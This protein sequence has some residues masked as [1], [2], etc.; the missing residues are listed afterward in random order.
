MYTLLRLLL[1][2]K[3]SAK[4]LQIFGMYKTLYKNNSLCLHNRLF[5]CKGLS[6][7]LQCERTFEVGRCSRAGVLE[8]TTKI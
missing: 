1:I 6:F 4:V 2:S 8:D 7:A 3:S 5:L